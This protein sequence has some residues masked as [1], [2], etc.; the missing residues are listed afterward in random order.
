MPRQ[1]MYA[2]GGAGSPGRLGRSG[3]LL[4]GFG[5]EPVDGRAGHVEGIETLLQQRLDHM[6][7][8]IAKGR[9]RMD[10]YTLELQQHGLDSVEREVRWLDELIATERSH[11]LDSQAPSGRLAPPTS[12]HGTVPSNRRK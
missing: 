5:H 11:D 3:R 7:D 6:R 4:S 10:A 8:N 12:G 9:E 2:C 1:C